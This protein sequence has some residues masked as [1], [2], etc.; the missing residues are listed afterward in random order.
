MAGDDL[1]PPEMKV[2]REDMRKARV[3]LNRRDYCA[4]LW[5][6]L[7]KCRQETYRWPWHCGTEQ[8]NYD[9]CVY[10]ELERRM[11]IAAAA[12]QRA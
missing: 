3:P 5:I 6:D 11:R 10:Q 9:Y 4:H 1:S 12:K 7:E 2:S 8:H